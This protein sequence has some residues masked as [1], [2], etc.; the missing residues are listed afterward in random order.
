MSQRLNQSNYE[1]AIKNV[2]QSRQIRQL[3]NIKTNYI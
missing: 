2:V 1:Q 3:P